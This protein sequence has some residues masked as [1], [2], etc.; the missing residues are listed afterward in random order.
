MR[1]Y[2]QFFCFQNKPNFLKSKGERWV[3][4][5]LGKGG[6]KPE[7]GLTLLVLGNPGFA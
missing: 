4:G 2:Y 1:S 3:F 6:Q 5:F 7:K